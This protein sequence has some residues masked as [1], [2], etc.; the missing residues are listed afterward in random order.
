[1]THLHVK[2]IEDYFL[3]Q[4]TSPKVVHVF[5]YGSRVYGTAAETSDYDYYVVVDN[6]LDEAFTDQLFLTNGS[7]E[8]NLNVINLRQFNIL[9]NEHAVGLLECLQTAD[10][11]SGQQVP[12]KIDLPSLRRAFSEKASNS[13]VKSKKKIA[14]NDVRI[15]Q[16]SLFHSLRI[17]MFGIQLA[18]FGKISDFS[19][20]NSLFADIMSCE[21]YNVLKD[22]YQPIYNKLSSEF[23]AAAPLVKVK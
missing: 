5:A 19:Q 2:F 12:F 21:D 14:Q 6:R 22:T 18:K 10:L 16:K 20:A 3:R 7:D 17:L 9:Q 8:L 23:K 15:G 11:V 13:W 1:M 4:K